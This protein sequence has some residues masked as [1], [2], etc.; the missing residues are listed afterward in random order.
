M[1]STLSR[2]VSVLLLCLIVLAGVYTDHFFQENQRIK[3]IEQ[4]RL[5]IPMRAQA[6]MNQLLEQR[7]LIR[8]NGVV[9]TA[10][11]T[12]VSKNSSKSCYSDHLTASLKCEKASVILVDLH[13]CSELSEG[14]DCR[15]GGQICISF[16]NPEIDDVY[17]TFD[18]MNQDR[19]R[20]TITLPRQH[21]L[22]GKIQYVFEQLM[23]VSQIADREKLNMMLYELFMNARHDIVD[24]KMGQD[25][26]VTI[27]SAVH[28][29]L[30]AIH[31]FT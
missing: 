27:L 17:I 2:L 3:L 11:N 16:E 19:G 20:F 15:A 31:V 22:Q 5:E 7:G 9:H 10:S 13:N 24:K 30:S 25:F 23:D 28:H 4:H 12:P 18:L 6:V 8:L 14:H 1:S 29:Y 21:K 26:L